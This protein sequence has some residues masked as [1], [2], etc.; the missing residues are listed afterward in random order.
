M[1]LTA[2]AADDIALFSAAFAAF[3]DLYNFLP[4]FQPLPIILATPPAAS[5]IA[6]SVPTI[7]VSSAPDISS[8]SYAFLAWYASYAVQAAPAPQRAKGINGKN[9]VMYSLSRV[10]LEVNIASLRIISFGVGC[11]KSFNNIEKSSPIVTIYQ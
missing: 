3:L 10:F 5:V 8:R 11:T 1:L 2:A 4:N 7:L 6:I 9:S